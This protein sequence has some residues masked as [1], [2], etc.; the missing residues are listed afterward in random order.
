[1]IRNDSVHDSQ[2]FK[3]SMRIGP[4]FLAVFLLFASGS[5][6]QEGP[7]SGESFDVAQ[8]MRMFYGN[9]DVKAETSSTRLPK[10]TTSL[11]A[12]GEEQMTVRVLFQSFV[13]EPV[14]RQL[15]LL[16][17]AIPSNNENYDCHA[18]APVIGMAVFSKNGQK[19][20]MHASNRA[21]TF[22]GEWGKPPNSI[23]L[24]K[25]GPHHVAAKIVDVGKGTAGE[26]TEVLDLLVPWN[27]T[28]N[29]AIQRIDATLA[30]SLSAGVWKPVPRLSPRY[31][32]WTGNST[33]HTAVGTWQRSLRNLFKLAGVNGHPHMLR[34]TFAT[35]LLLAGVPIEQV[36]ILLGHSSVRITELHY[37]PWVRERQLQLEA[38]LQRAWGQDPLVLLEE[39]ATRK[40]QVQNPTIN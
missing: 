26:T 6:A 1:V 32:F 10:N 34:D 38:S 25:I 14:A 40:M 28:V 21:V 15:F 2:G 5:H 20:Q 4:S 31:F 30:C 19:W 27:G 37:R 7:T 39:E 11:P 18:C 29:L 24:V 13:S 8:A 22:S 16:T 33:L 9:Y 12:P 17:Y 35:E 23:Q 3:T 36:S